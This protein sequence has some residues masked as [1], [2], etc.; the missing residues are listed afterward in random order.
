MLR[1]SFL[2]SLAVS[3]VVL[4]GACSRQKVQPPREGHLRVVTWNLEWFPGHVPEPT[5]E[6]QKEHMAAAKEAVTSL[7]PDIFLAQEVRDWAAVA[8]LVSVDP[9]LQIH[10]VSQFGDR[11]QNQAVASHLNADSAWSAAWKYGPANPPRGYAF[12]ALRLPDNRFLLCYSL[13]LKSNLGELRSNIAMRHESSRQLLQ[14]V[15]EMLKVYAQRAPCGV[16]VAGDMNTSLDDP[17]FGSDASIRALI[18][19]GFYWTHEGVPFEKRTTIPADG[20]FPDNCFDHVLTLGLGKPVAAAKPFPKISDHYPV[21]VD[22]DLARADFQPKL[23]VAAGERTLQEIGPIPETIPASAPAP[24]LA[25]GILSASDDAAI[26]AAVGQTAAVQG[27][28]SRV[29]ATESGSI[30]FI[31]FT[32]ND[33]GKFVAIVRKERLTDVAAAFGGDLQSLA[34]KTVEVHGT[35]ELYRNTPEIVVGQPDQLRAVA[36]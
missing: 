35:I 36:P 15:S 33:R 23:D 26:R 10:L 9:S 6:Q 12:A 14:H 34:G 32:G 21:I 20:K 4:H 7:K 28:V 5:L 29:G 18:A 17:K 3:L 27:T 8:D 16:I 13:H 25:D 22:I 30:T 11:P 31:N 24:K 1:R 2:L 19:A